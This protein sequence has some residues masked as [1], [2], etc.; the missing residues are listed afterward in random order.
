MCAWSFGNLITVE[1]RKANIEDHAAAKALDSKITD[2][3]SKVRGMQS[4][5]QKVIAGT[6]P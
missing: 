6:R 1:L 4:L 5:T 3:F 2:T